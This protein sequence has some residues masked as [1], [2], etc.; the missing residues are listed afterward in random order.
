MG[1]GPIFEVRGDQPQ[2]GNVVHKDATGNPTGDG[3]QDR[4]REKLVRE[5]R[6]AQA[7][8]IWAESLWSASGD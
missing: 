8:S 2:G 4:L 1:S 7:R 3:G 6:R 5:G